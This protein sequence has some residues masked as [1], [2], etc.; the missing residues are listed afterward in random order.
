[1][2][3]YILE[4]EVIQDLVGGEFERENPVPQ[5]KLKGWNKLF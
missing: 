5:S 4:E 3:N 1:M 2:S